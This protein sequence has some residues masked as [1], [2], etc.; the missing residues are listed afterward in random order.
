MTIVTHE[1]DKIHS[2][3]NNR[4]KYDKLI[5][6]NCKTCKNTQNPHFYKFEKLKERLNNGKMAIECGNSPYYEVNIQ[7]LIDDAIDK[8]KSRNFVQPK[9]STNYTINNYTDSVININD[10]DVIGSQTIA[11]KF[12]NDQSRN[13]E[14]K[15][16]NVV[17]NVL[18]DESNIR[19]KVKANSPQPKVYPQPKR[20]VTAN[21]SQPKISPQPKREEAKKF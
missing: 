5:P 7:S 14:N 2:S 15:N 20:K 6:C 4:L 8:D 10:N 9:D 12:V 19:N 13:I 11:E 21:S 18:G 1:L 16:G 3:Y 17:G